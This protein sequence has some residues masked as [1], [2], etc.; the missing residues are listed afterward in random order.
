MPVRKAKSLRNL[1]MHEYF[2]TEPEI[3]WDTMVSEIPELA[4]LLSSGA[5]PADC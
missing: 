2:R 1:L 5:S 3:L 4:R